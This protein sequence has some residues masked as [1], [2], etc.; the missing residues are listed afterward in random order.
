MAP[1]TSELVNMSFQ[2]IL[3]DLD[4]T[5]I[6]SKGTIMRCL[7][8]TMLEYGADP[9]APDDIRELTGQSLAGILS[10]RLELED[11]PAATA[12]YRERQMSTY[13]KDMAIIEGGLEV[14]EAVRER[15]IPSA[16]VTLR[17]GDLARTILEGMD[18]LKY[19]AVVVGDGD[20]EAPKPSPAPVL[21]A[22]ELLAV[23]PAHALVVGDTVYDVKSARGAGCPAAAVTWGYFT[24][25]DL[26]D[27]GADYLIDDWKDFYGLLD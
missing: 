23:D 4:G 12:Y 6:D 3:F 1:T 22:C 17:K 15:G 16:A 8:D 25:E 2:A 21:K 13:L 20:A 18:L 10:N 26:K 14:L 5:L 7:N 9:F 11:I 27:A 19:F 24:A